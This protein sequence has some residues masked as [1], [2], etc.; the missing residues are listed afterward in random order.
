MSK[1]TFLFL[2][3]FNSCLTLLRHHPIIQLPI[4]SSVA[5]KQICSAAIPISIHGKS[6]FFNQPAKRVSGLGCSI[7]IAM[8]TGASKANLLMG[9]P[10]VMVA[11]AISVLVGS[12]STT[13]NV[14]GCELLAEGANRALSIICNIFG[15]NGWW[16]IFYRFGVFELFRKSIVNRAYR[17]L[18][19]WKFCFIKHK[20]IIHLSSFGLTFIISK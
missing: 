2:G 9:K 4:P 13:T 12:L 10:L 3:I 19:P 11:L 17:L 6:R 5:C 15:C 16:Y 7:T 8:I 20:Q 1:P 14:H 18:Q